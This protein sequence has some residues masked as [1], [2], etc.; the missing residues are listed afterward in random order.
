MEFF[1][2]GRRGEKEDEDEGEM[3]EEEEEWKEWKVWSFLVE[4][5]GD[6]VGGKAAIR[7]ENRGNDTT[8]R[9]TVKIASSPTSISSDVFY[10]TDIKGNAQQR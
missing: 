9:G 4:S 3:E 5:F 6:S 10:R 2:P 8:V 1:F 7:T